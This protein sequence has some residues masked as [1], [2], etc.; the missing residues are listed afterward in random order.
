[1]LS[2]VKHYRYGLFHIM[3]QNKNQNINSIRQNLVDMEKN[4]LPVLSFQNLSKNPTITSI[5]VGPA[6]CEKLKGIY[7]HENVQEKNQH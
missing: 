6:E 7:H 2:C 4:V 5:K 1:M 3:Q